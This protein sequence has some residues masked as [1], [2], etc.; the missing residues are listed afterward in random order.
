MVIR[1]NRI[2]IG[3]LRFEHIGLYRRYRQHDRHSAFAVL[4]PF[5]PLT[6]VLEV[7]GGVYVVWHA[8]VAFDQDPSK[9]VCVYM[10]VRVC[11]YEHL[12]FCCVFACV[13]NCACCAKAAFRRAHAATHQHLPYPS[14]IITTSTTTTTSAVPAVNDMTRTGTALHGTTWHDNGH[15]MLLHGGVWHDL[16]RHWLAHIKSLICF[17]LRSQ[18]WRWRM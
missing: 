1:I 11:M 13:C 15:S 5:V 6:T 12:V 17:G 8:E 2:G 9:H 14:S 4:N 10:R 16:E 3:R 18:S 7:Y